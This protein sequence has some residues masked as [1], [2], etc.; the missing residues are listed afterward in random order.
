V[1]ACG[2]LAYLF[3]E[4]TNRSGLETRV[5]GTVG[6]DHSWNEIKLYD[7]WIHVDP[8]IYYLNYHNETSVKWFDNPNCYEKELHWFKI[9]RVIVYE[10]G[11]D[12][13]QN[14]TKLGKM[15]ISIIGKA[16]KI[17]ITTLKDNAP[18]HVYSQSLNTSN[19]EVELGGKV[20]TVTAEKD[21]IPYLPS[22]IS[23]QD[24]KEVEVIE[25]EETPVELLPKKLSFKRDFYY[26]LT[27]MCIYFVLIIFY[28]KKQ[29]RQIRR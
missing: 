11:E 19:L 29:K 22:L 27:I 10:T 2:E 14:Y 6:E 28:L 1:G 26:V 12:V 16:D 24:V 21:F 3:Y 8:T 4:V 5:V 20:Y 7:K 17:Y 23:R 9:S 25:G 18:R 15:N 13:T